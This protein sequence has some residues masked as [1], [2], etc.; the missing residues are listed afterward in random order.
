M[1]GEVYQAHGLLEAASVAY[2]NARELNPQDELTIFNLG[3]IYQERGDMASAAVA[4]EEVISRSPD[5]LYAL[6]QLGEV[7]LELGELGAAEQAFRRVLE[8]DVA[9]AAAHYGLGQVA[10]MR[11]DPEGAARHFQAALELQP[12]ATILHYALARA[13]RSQGEIE[14]ARFHLE[15]RGEE[16][17]RTADPRLDRISRIAALSAV[18]SVLGMAGDR[19]D[20]SAENFL[21]FAIDKLGETVGSIELL[22]AV[23]EARGVDPPEDGEAETARI[24]YA[25]GG[26]LAQQASATE[27]I[28]H[29]RAA[30]E[31]LPS[32]SE[33][34]MKLA[35]ALARTGDFAAAVAEYDRLMTA[36][37]GDPEIMLHRAIALGKQGDDRSATIDLL[38]VTQLDPQAA[39]GW[40][41]LAAARERLADPSAAVSAYKMALTLDLVDRERGF[42]HLRLARLLRQG[43]DL[44]AAV[45]HYESALLVESEATEARFELAGILGLLDRYDEA[46]A[47]YALVVAAE[48]G[49]EAARLGEA[50]ALIF[51]ERWKEAARRLESGHRELP[52]NGSLSHLLAR[53]LAAAPDPSLRDGFRALQ[54]AQELFTERHSLFVGETVAM[55]LAES[56]DT[57]RAAVLQRSLLEGAR[58]AE[59]TMVVDRLEANLVRYESGNACCTHY[60]PTNLLP[61]LENAG[62]GAAGEEH[63]GTP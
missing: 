43:G 22:Q 9:S 57:E 53:L 62:G 61:P 15:L 47:Q 50:S 52:Q 7:R 56:G 58:R 20:F 30:T 29:F 42:V 12:E 51:A 48:P 59:L 49:H 63:P 3:R 24:H 21:G 32:F 44:A 41:H 6:I 54:I 46:V 34:R 27:A 14:K 23:A 25:I 35:D 2:S 26:L 8:T 5:D 16:K 1:L 18:G 28:T 17:V 19:K 33:A 10:A 60:G 31:L 4:F 40:L 37:P 13:Y 55:A 36:D 38:R 39:E 11:S 45:T